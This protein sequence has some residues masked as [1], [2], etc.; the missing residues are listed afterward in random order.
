MHLQY[1][2]TSA[3]FSGR[4]TVSCIL[5]SDPLNS[6][7]ANREDKRFPATP[8][9]NSDRVLQVQYLVESGFK[10][11]VQPRLRE[12]TRCSSS[13]NVVTRSEARDPVARPG[14]PW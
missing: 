8:I 2:L 9:L 6:V 7:L 14:S 5:A 1:I 12:L 3:I 13:T 10:L 11:Q 4:Q